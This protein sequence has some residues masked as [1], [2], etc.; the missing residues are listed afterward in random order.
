M[1]Y[2]AFQKLMKRND[3]TVFQSC[4][5]LLIDDQ[6]THYL[7][8]IFYKNNLYFIPKLQRYTVQFSQ[9][10]LIHIKILKSVI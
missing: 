10:A 4:K 1:G 6:K 2:L 8:F 5:N 3:N 9:I 7:M